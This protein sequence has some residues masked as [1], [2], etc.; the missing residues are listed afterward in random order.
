MLKTVNRTAW[1]ASAMSRMRFVPRRVKARPSSPSMRTS[2]AWP[3]LIS[4]MMWFSAAPRPLRNG[5]MP[6]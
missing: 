5:A 4:G 1:A 6:K 2:A 3:M